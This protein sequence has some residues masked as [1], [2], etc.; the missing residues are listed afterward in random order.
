MRVGGGRRGIGAAHVAEALSAHCPTRFEV[1]ASAT[2]TRPEARGARRRARRRAGR[3]DL[4][5]AAARCDD[6]DLIDICTPPHLHF[7]QIRRR[8]RPA[9]TSICEKPLVGSLR[10]VDAADRGRSGVGRAGDADL[11]VPLRPWATEA[12]AHRR[13]G[14]GR[15]GPISRRSRRPGGG[16]P[17]TTPCPGAASGR[18]SWAARWS[19][20]RSTPT[21]CSATSSARSRASSPAPPRASTPSRSRTAP[22]PRL[23]MADGALASLSVT[24]GSAGEISRHRFCFEH[25]TESNIAAYSPAIRLEIF[26]ATRPRARRRSTA[27]LA[28]AFLP[29]ASRA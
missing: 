29:R 15:A 5:D 8:W 24:L 26:P 6:L 25:V 16:A 28:A 19:A 4:A 1:R 14:P 3:T 10:E 2:S 23:E 17:P 7:A 11:P 13:R 12:Q 22:R 21:T 9:S 18:P 27:A 20:T